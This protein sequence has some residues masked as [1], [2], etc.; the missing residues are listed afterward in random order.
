MELVPRLTADGSYTLYHAALN[1]PYHS[2]HGALRESVH[3]F[4][5]QGLRFVQRRNPALPSPLHLLEVGL[6]TGLNA[7]LAMQ[8]AAQMGLSVVY[9]ALE[10]FPVP[11]EA[12]EALRYEQ[13][14]QPATPDEQPLLAPGA[15]R[16]I[17]AA[18]WET[19]VHLSPSFI[20]LKLKTTLQALPTLPTPADL[21][22]YDAFAPRKQPEMWEVPALACA[23]KQMAPGGVL[24]TYCAKGQFK[25]DLAEAGFVVEKKVQGPPGKREMTRAHKPD[26]L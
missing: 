15:L 1:E 4:I 14:E 21:V 22:F 26:T 23:W 17:H 16:A 9:T 18:P 10:P 24:V 5:E 25:R 6:G 20:L 13:L 12:W 8:A 3:V 19:T 7:A 11:A 2:C